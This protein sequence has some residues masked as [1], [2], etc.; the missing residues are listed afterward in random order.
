MLLAVVQVGAGL[1]ERQDGGLTGK[2][3][4]RCPGPVFSDE[5]VYFGAVVEEGYRTARFDPRLAA[6][7]Y[8]ACSCT[9]PARPP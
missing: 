2:Q 1:I 9:R 3:R 4:S 8:R 7:R 6:V 5:C